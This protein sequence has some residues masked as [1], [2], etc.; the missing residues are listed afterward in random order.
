MNSFLLN[1]INTA[2]DAEMKAGSQHSDCSRDDFPWLC[3]KPL[4]AHFVTLF[5]QPTIPP[6]TQ[7]DKATF[8]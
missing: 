4:K 5:H 7:A 3:G 6:Q 8:N 2:T 1:V